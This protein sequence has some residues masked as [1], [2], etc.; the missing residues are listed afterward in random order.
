MSVVDFTLS[1]DGVLAFQN[2]LTCIMK[3]SDDVF[4]D[5]RR[6]KVSTAHDGGS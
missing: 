1:E 4:L 6:D 5:A 3:F 2:A